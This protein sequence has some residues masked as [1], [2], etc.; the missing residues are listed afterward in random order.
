M[1]NLKG[2]ARTSGTDSSG[3]SLLSLPTSDKTTPQTRCLGVA[4]AVS[5]TQRTSGYGGTHGEGKQAERPKHAH[6]L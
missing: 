1:W 5:K 2:D 3:K 4:G 6:N